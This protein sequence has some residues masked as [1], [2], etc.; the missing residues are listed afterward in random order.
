MPIAKCTAYSF[1]GI[2]EQQDEEKNKTQPF[3]QAS[4]V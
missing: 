3:G 4:Y 2:S 1:C